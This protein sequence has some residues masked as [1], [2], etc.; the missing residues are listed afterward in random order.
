MLFE[1]STQD[2]EVPLKPVKSAD[3]LLDVILCFFFSHWRDIHN[4]TDS[5]Q[6]LSALYYKPASFKG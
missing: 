1:A 3:D 6:P 2:V 5:Q 4:L